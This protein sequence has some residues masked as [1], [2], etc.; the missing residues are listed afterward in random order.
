MSN[1]ATAVELGFVTGLWNAEDLVEV[2]GTRWIVA[3]GMVGPEHP[4][5]HL[6]LVDADAKTGEELFPAKVEIRPAGAPYSEDPPD[7]E[8]FDAHGLHLRPGED[9]VHT[10]YLVNH[11]GREAI[12]VFEVDARGDEPAVAWIGAI[13]QHPGVWGNAVAPLPDGGIVVTNYLDLNDPNAFDKVYAAEITG[14]IKEWHA[15]RG[16][17]DVPGTECSAPNGVDVSP[18]GRWCFIA[19]WSAKK[20]IRVSRGAAEVQRDEQP[21]GFLADNV[22]WHAD[23][24]ITVAGQDSEPET[25]FAGVGAHAIVHYPVHV[26]KV[27]PETLAL[28]E[29]VRV[30]NEHFGTAASGVE[31]NGV[32]WIS[33]ARGDRVAYVLDG[34]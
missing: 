6:Y 18:D 10:L 22:K 5:G 7:P 2:P 14:N 20:L 9:G 15:D 27:D 33:N 1:D 13:I 3:S 21:L 16:W 29:L 11:G 17:E 8:S 26:V 34:E 4:S 12:E 28:T 32:L 19:S 23:G 31:I 30:E 24:T 25:V